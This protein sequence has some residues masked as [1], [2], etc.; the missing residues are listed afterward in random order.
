MRRENPL[1]IRHQK[2]N[3]IRLLMRDSNKS[4]ARLGVI[5]VARVFQGS[6]RLGIQVIRKCFTQ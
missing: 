4:K 5:S 6:K 3:L 2:T 1:V